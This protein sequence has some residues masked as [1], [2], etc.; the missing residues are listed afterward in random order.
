MWKRVLIFTIFI[1]GIRGLVSAQGSPED[2]VYQYTMQVYGGTEY[3]SPAHFIQNKEFI[4]R[5]HILEINDE[6][7]F[8]YT[9]LSSIELKDKYNK[10]IRDNKENFNPKDFNPLKY[11]FNFYNRDHSMYYRVD[12][13]HFYIEIKVKPESK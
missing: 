10:L 9:H 7:D 6:P 4:D 11:R 13:T 2:L 12:D 1:S 8:E 3:T 5:V